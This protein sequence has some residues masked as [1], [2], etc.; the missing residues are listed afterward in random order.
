MFSRREWLFFD[1]SRRDV[2]TRYFGF[3]FF[4]DFVFELL[5]L[6]LI[7]YQE[8]D[9][10]QKSNPDK[11]IG[12]GAR[13]CA[14]KELPTLRVGKLKFHSVTLRENN[15]PASAGSNRFSLLTLHYM[16]FIHTILLRR[17]EAKTI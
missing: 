13:T 9:K 17:E 7:P 1:F 2:Y 5:L 12:T 8:R 10:L 16:K 15:S 14:E 4:I 6:F 3:D 11:D